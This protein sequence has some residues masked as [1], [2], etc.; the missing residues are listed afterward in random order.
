[1]DLRNHSLIK[2]INRAKILNVIRESSPIARSQIAEKTGLD[3]KSITNFITE[4]LSDG[5]VEEA[6]KQDNPSGRPYT[7]LKFKDKFAIGIYL[8][9]HY[10]RGILI[11]IYGNII[12]SH[13]E[14]YPLYS[15]LPVLVNAVKKIHE[16][17]SAVHIPDCGVGICMPG[18]MDIEND[19][20]I[21]SVNIPALK[22]K[23][24]RQIFEEFIKEPL[25]FEEE[26][27]SIALAEKWFGRGRQYDDFMVVEV[28]G[29]IGAGIVNNRRLF[30]GAGQYAGEVGHVVIK[31]NGAQCR[32]GNCG[33]LEA[34]ASER[35][36]AN[37]LS[38]LS[39]QKISRL[40][41]ADM[42]KITQDTY[43]QIL[44]EAG[45]NLGAGLAA[46][47][48]ILCPRVIILS[49]S[50]INFFN[51]DILEPIKQSITGK[52]LKGSFEQTEIYI[53]KLNLIDALGAATLPLSEIFEVPEYFYV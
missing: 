46:V 22:G 32:C 33:C 14:E 29:G 9:P 34:Y 42:N 50:V 53:S 39:G 10:A 12:H 35:A 17:L 27:R 40:R 48:N 26:S 52:C 3:R 20:M 45:E 47:V 18:I 24:F 51:E 13:E 41:H 8:A 7:M 23:N 44:S 36:I 4:L 30:K 5:L 25:F 16:Q 19:V 1:M 31:E 6:G 11:D 28:S 15:E 38:E 2:Q 43:Q 37:K 49:G 21:N